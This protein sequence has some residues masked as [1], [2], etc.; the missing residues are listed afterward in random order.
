MML[1]SLHLGYLLGVDSEQLSE[2]A[3]ASWPARPGAELLSG[4]SITPEPH[5]PATLG[6]SATATA[7]AIDD[8]G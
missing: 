4:V 1:F 7:W 6:E 5:V 2:A 3:S 8:A